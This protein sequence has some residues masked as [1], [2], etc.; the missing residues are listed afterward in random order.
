ML[1]SVDRKLLFELNWNC[2]QSNTRLG[3]K[4]RVSKQVIGYRISQLE[5]NKHLLAYSPLIDW[6]K[7]GY[8]A[9]RVYLKWKNINKR[10]EEEIYASMKK[11]DFFMWTVNLEGEFD[12]AFYIWVKDFLEFSEKW[13]NFLSKHKKFILKQEICESVNMV[14]F[15][16]KPLIEKF[17]PEEKIIGAGKPV[18]FDKKD[19]EILR[20]LNENSR[21]PI[22]EISKKIK[23]TPKA[24]ICRIKQLEKKGIILG[25]NAFINYNKLGYD[26]YKADFYLNDLSRTKEMLDF[27]RKHKN[28]VYLMR[29]IGGPD[30][31]IEAMVSNA[32]EL[33]KLINEIR[34]KFSECIEYYR[35]HRFEQTIKQVYLPGE[36]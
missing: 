28:I 33:T 3:K 35:Y 18:E 24:V 31:E 6:R 29:T 16:M 26:F 23:L 7:L 4:L 1:D 13:F 10:I 34:E 5:K 2:R 22:V 27:A 17:V 19:L 12:L 14:F 9:I 36:I 15:P 32:S 11:D 30:Y 21:M 8:N 25:Y 20:A